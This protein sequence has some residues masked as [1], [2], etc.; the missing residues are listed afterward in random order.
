MNHCSV[1]IVTII[2]SLFSIFPLYKWI[3]CTVFMFHYISQV[4]GFCPVSQGPKGL[5]P[6]PQQFKALLHKIEGCIEASGSLS[7]LQ[8]SPYLLY[9]CAI[10]SRLSGVFSLDSRMRPIGKSL[11]F[12]ADILL[13]IRLLSIHENVSLL[14]LMMVTYSFYALSKVKLKKCLVSAIRNS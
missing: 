10:Q 1:L 11:L 2:I 14:L 5:V 3:N 9:A 4:Q 7:L 6:L 13:H 12:Q 8:L